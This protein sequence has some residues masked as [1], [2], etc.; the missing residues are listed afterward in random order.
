[1]KGEVGY[2]T[3]NVVTGIATTNAYYKIGSRLS[4]A[5]YGSVSFDGLGYDIESIF[6]EFVVNSF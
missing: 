4:F 3:Y 1:L 6:A 2:D 5:T